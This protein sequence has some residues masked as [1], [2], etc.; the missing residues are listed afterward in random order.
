MEG[1]Q[2]ICKYCRNVFITKSKYDS[3]YKKEHQEQ[4]KNS[5]TRS[6]DGLFVCECGKGYPVLGSLT[7]HKQ[8]YD[9]QK[10]EMVSN[11]KSATQEMEDM[12][13]E[14]LPLELDM[15]HKII[16]CT[17][18]CISLPMEWVCSHLKGQHEITTRIDEVQTVVQ[19]VEEEEGGLTVSQ[20]KEWLSETWILNEL[21]KGIP[22]V[23]GWKCQICFYSCVNLRAMK[24][25][26]S[27]MHI[28]DS[29]QQ[30][31]S[32]CKVQCVFQGQLQ[33]YIV[34]EDNGDV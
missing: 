7:R 22:V 29:W 2:W 4:T 19:V 26:F 13:L 12:R 23:D 34:V 11:V 6:E 33:K 5:I 1:T 32:R 25:H 3:Q 24:N 14:G 30:D 27:K 17:G 16:I 8:R 20:A 21:V 10:A 18:C 15:R 9:G 28:R 31:T